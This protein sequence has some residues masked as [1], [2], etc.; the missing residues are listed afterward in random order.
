MQNW[1]S[2][3][4]NV[5]I[6]GFQEALKRV[7]AVSRQ[8]LPKIINTK[9]FFIAIEARRATPSVSRAQIEQELGV[10]GYKLEFGKRGKILKSSRK[11]KAANAITD[12]TSIA[13]LIINA[14]MGRAKKKGLRGAEMR[15]AVG[16]LLAKRFRSR[17]T[18]KG[19][20]SGG[21][22]T[23]GNSVG[24]KAG[25]DGEASK[26]MGRST[27]R[28]A[29][30]GWSPKLQL[31]YQ[32][33]SFDQRHSAYIDKRV[34]TAWERGVRKEIANMSQYTS[35]RLGKRIKQAGIRVEAPTI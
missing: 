13:H 12:S 24:Q 18:L 20:W 31:T 35:A 23:L 28:P 22:N 19:G 8:E 7:V 11:A 15:I 2:P 33:N 10:K 25:K 30:E 5:H 26:V 4:A 34:A 17:G 14:R 32:V 21:I 9:G 29:Q 6:D 27:A 16:K 3:H 1:L